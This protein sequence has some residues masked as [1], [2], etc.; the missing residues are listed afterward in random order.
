MSYIDI[1]KN[2]YEVQKN[3]LNDC[4]RVCQSTEDRDG[5]FHILNAL[6]IL[7]RK[8][9]RI[10]NESVPVVTVHATFSAS[11]TVQGHEY[12][13][14]RTLHWVIEESTGLNHICTAK[15]LPDF[16][17]HGAVLNANWEQV[18]DVSTG[19][20]SYRADI[21][22]PEFPA[23]LTLAPIREFNLKL[24]DYT[25]FDHDKIAKDFIKAACEYDSPEKTVINRTYE[26]LQEEL[27]L[28]YDRV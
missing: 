5:S 25:S 1:A 13:S 19:S 27:K 3:Y 14:D 7:E 21:L 6:E 16:I 23:H 4:M 8:F 17:P 18:L 2:I 10:I 9:D 28:R 22:S 11:F 26:T 12:S 15:S 20:K 24:P